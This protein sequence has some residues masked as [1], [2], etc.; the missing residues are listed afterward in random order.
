MSYK[1]TDSF[2]KKKVIKITI[3]SIISLFVVITFFNSFTTIKSGEIGLKSRFGQIV[4]QTT[5][6]GIQFKVPY[7]EKVTKVNMKVQKAD[8]TSS[9]ATKDLQDVSIAFAINYQLQ[10]DKVMDLYKTV[11]ASYVETILQPATQEALKNVTSKY[12]AEELITKRSEVS[13]QIIQDLSAKVNKYG[14]IINELNIIDLNFSEAY[15]KAIEDKQVA[16]QEVKK[17]QQELEKTKIEAEKKVAEAQAE[18]DA[19]RLQKEEITDELLEL[20]RIE[21]QTKAIEKWNGQLP[22]TI[23]GTD[24]IPFIN[25]K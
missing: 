14:I 6:E 24:S 20:R 15:N 1:D 8:I 12:T 4:S 13:Q 25:L 16:E 5:Q 2:N 23:T 7:I 9:S 22:S 21:A 17:A 18:A 3:I 10:A 11:G 19:L